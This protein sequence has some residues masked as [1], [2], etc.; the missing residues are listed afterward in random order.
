MDRY[1][2]M[3]FANNEAE[4]AANRFPD[5]LHAGCHWLMVRQTMGHVPKRLRITKRENTYIGSVIRFNSSTWTVDEFDGKHALIRLRREDGIPSRWEHISDQRLEWLTV[6]HEKSQEIVPR[7]SWKRKIGEI[8]VSNDYLK[9][10]KSKQVTIDNALTEY[11]KCGRTDYPGLPWEKWRV[12]TAFTREHV[13]TPSRPKPRTLMSSD[14]HDFRVEWMTYF[15]A[16]CDVYSISID[17]FSNALYNE[18]VEKVCGLFPQEVQST[19]REKIQIWQVPTEYIRADLK[20][21]REEC[22]PVILFEPKRLGKSKTEFN[23]YI[24]DMSFVKP[25]NTN[26]MHLQFQRLFKILWGDAMQQ[27]VPGPMNIHFFSNILRA[28]KKKSPMAAPFSDFGVELFTYQKRCLHWLIERETTAPPISSWGWSRRKLED[29]F[30]FHNSVFGQISLTPPNT[31][32]RGG[33]LAQEMGM[34]K[35]VEMLALIATHKAPGPTLVVVPTTMLSVWLTE[36]KRYTPF[37]KLIKF[38]GSRR[39]KDMDLLRNADIVVTT[40]R[41][42]VNET[43]QHIPTIG[44]IR[45]GRIILDESHESRHHHSKTTRAICRLFAPYRWCVSATPWPK[46]YANVCSMLAFLSVTPFDDMSEDRFF[47]AQLTRHN[48]AVIPSLM[49]QILT[50]C[51]W[52]QQKRHVNMALPKITYNETTVENECPLL[53]SH[54]ENVIR[55]HIA[56]D[57]IEANHRARLMHYTRWLRQAA[58]HPLL[59]RISDYGFIRSDQKVHSQQSSIE[60][61]MNTLGST[62][63]DNSLKDLI[64]SWSEGNE[65]CSICMDA[66]DRPTIT[67]CHHMFCFECIQSAYQHD[68]QQKCPLCRKPVGNEHLHELSIDEPEL[69]EECDLNWV[70]SNLQGQTVEMEKSIYK[71]LVHQQTQYG[72]KIKTILQ[73]IR[74][75][76]DEKFLI[77]TQF[78]KSWEK[79]CEIFKKENILYTCIE[80]RM[81]PKQRQRS[82]DLFQNDKDTKIFIMTTKT[83]AVGIT[84]TAASQIVFLEPGLAAHIRKQAIGR[85]WRIGQTRCVNVTT[86]KTSGTIDCV[87]ESNLLTYFNIQNRAT[88]TGAYV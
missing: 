63:Y 6:L 66:I 87:S 22:L 50:E 40:Y 13:H 8:T 35:T 5:D 16:I 33:L 27:S 53:Y 83:A 24:H 86:L 80:G 36:A 52:W 55:S 84:L 51:T 3:G 12:I 23:V 9:V 41:V 75:K 70:G 18:S 11:V 47:C 68:S 74:D 14:V 30:E 82:I 67:P 1:I 19:L 62:N 48:P 20:K 38:H 85:A 69:L 31:T 76:P 61:F 56:R 37:L 79:C 46:G 34:G 71:Q 25:N 73:L 57:A 4:E 78:H 58:V 43:Q 21:W 65:K 49:C 88:L 44:A 64:I 45:W 72:A 15:H 39:T 32:V 54:L 77:F 42:V 60:K 59:N 10:S 26:S 7:L 81:S 29:G 17:S 28:S 2:E